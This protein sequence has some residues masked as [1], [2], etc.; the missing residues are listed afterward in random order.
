MRNVC[1]AVLVAAGLSLSACSFSSSRSWGSG[2]SATPGN[3]G[4][5]KPARHTSSAGKPAKHVPQAAPKA[6]DPAPAA[7][8][9]PA[10]PEAKAPTEPVRVGRDTVEPAAT[11]PSGTT[12]SA[13]PSD[14]T[15]PKPGNKLQLGA[16]TSGGTSKPGADSGAGPANIKAAPPQPQPRPQPPA[17]KTATPLN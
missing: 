2:N 12:L 16:G 1:L 13:K 17:G 15:T 14:P 7:Q 9:T 11:T 4:Q 3:S 5:G 8:P 6:A 10:E